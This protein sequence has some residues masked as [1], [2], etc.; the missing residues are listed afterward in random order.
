MIPILIMKSNDTPL[1]G[2]GGGMARAASLT[3][4]DEA[5]YQKWMPSK[6]P[7]NPLQPSSHQIVEPL[8][9]SHPT[10][11]SSYPLRSE[12]DVCYN[13]VV[14]CIANAQYQDILC[15]SQV[16]YTSVA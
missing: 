5:F 6:L 7:R 4:N 16:S 11:S 14:F 12:V 3:Y 13:K 8:S 15:N 9:Q 1:D 10:P 2:V